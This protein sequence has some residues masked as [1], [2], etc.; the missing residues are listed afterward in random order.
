MGQAAIAQTNGQ[1]V[2]LVAQN[3]VVRLHL[4]LDIPAVEAVSNG[5]ENYVIQPRNYQNLRP[6]SPLEIGVEG[7]EVLFRRLDV[8]PLKSTQPGAP[9]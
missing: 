5:G 8:Y 1:K 3:G 4:L 6:G 2:R 9:R 7:G